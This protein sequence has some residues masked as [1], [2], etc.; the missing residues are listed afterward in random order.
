MYI[1][2]RK[3]PCSRSNFSPHTVQV[4]RILGKLVKIEERKMVPVRQR[5]HSCRRMAEAAEWPEDMQVVY[6]ISDTGGRFSPPVEPALR[7]PPHPQHELFGWLFSVE[8]V[9]HQLAGGEVPAAAL[10]SESRFVADD[11]DGAEAAVGA[12]IGGMI[13]HGVLAAQG[14]FDL[15]ETMFQF[16]FLARGQDVAAGRFGDLRHD[17]VALRMLR[18][19]KVVGAEHVDDGLG[20]LGGLD[21]VVQDGLA[22]RIHAVADQDDGF[23][24][25]AAAVRRAQLVAGADDRVVE[26]GVAAGIHVVDG[27]RKL[28]HVAGRVLDQVHVAVKSDDKGLVFS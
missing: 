11:L 8:I 6:S 22:G 18:L 23:A 19:K 14:S 3:Y 2:P 17:G 4:W 7:P 16:V 28:T 21:G 15:G 25:D 27:A 9:G 10:Y 12:E 24:R 13:A 5:G 1:A 20:A 26:R